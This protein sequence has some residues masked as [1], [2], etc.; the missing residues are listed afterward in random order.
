MSRMMPKTRLASGHSR[1][2]WKR[3][4]ADGAGW[5]ETMGREHIS[6][7]FEIECA[8]LAMRLSS[9]DDIDSA[10]RIAARIV[11]PEKV[12][13]KFVFPSPET[14]RRS[15]IKVDMMH[16]L[17]TRRL[18]TEPVRVARFIMPDSS[19]QGKCDYFCCKDD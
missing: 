6:P 1:C 7:A 16:M 8:R 14:V 13:S 11:C 5:K 17:F 4:E 2:R 15:I 12:I 19:P 9:L 10:C 18:F 3:G